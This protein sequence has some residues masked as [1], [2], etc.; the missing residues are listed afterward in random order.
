MKGSW[1]KQIHKIGMVTLS[2]KTNFDDEY[3]GWQDPQQLI[4]LLKRWFK[5]FFFSCFIDLKKAEN[6]H[7]S[8]Q[9]SLSASLTFKN[10]SLHGH[11]M[12]DYQTTKW[13]TH[14][15]YIIK[16]TASQKRKTPYGA[17]QPI[18]HQKLKPHMGI[19]W[20]T[21]S[22]TNHKMKH[23]EFAHHQTLRISKEKKCKALYLF[24]NQ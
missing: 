7:W 3:D 24:C 5:I 13:N 4:Q 6:S 2:Q 17:L 10:E 1:V 16:S 9:F 14:S 22:T 23:I 15:S 11:M 12:V 8:Y 18:W 21:I 19:W 20:W